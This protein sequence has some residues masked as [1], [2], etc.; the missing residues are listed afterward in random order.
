MHPTKTV[1]LAG[2]AIAGLT[3]LALAAGSSV[4]EMTVDMPGGGVAHIRYTGDLAPKVN[5]V[6]TA[7]GG[8]AAAPI[9]FFGEPSAFAEMDRIS[10][11]MDRQMAMLMQQA[12]LMHLRVLQNAPLTS[13]EF[14]TLPDG[15]GYSFVST[16]SGN[17]VCM[18]SVQ[19]TTLGNEAPKVVSQTSGNCGD[20]K[21][22]RPANAAAGQAVPL[23]TIS[24]KPDAAHHSRQ[25]I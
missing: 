19:I 13:A 12:S 23:Q 16:L 15:S 10:A 18:K 1:I 11:L 9:G 7:A 21:A 22:A 3:G 5:F 8:L 17:G 6:R 4:H 24:Y 25:G 20:A 2:A 14:K